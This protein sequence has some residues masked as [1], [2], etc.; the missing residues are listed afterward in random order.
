M[1]L[2]KANNNRN[3]VHYI[4]RTNQLPFQYGLGKFGFTKIVGVLSLSYH[5]DRSLSYNFMR[6]LPVIVMIKSFRKPPADKL[7]LPSGGHIG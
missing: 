6:F 7:N 4:N 5:I 1:Y 2:W 3:I